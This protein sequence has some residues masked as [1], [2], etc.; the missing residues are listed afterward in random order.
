VQ[1]RS[2]LAFA[3]LFAAGCPDSNPGFDF[4][5]PGDAGADAQ[6][7]PEAMPL[8]AADTF[9]SCMAVADGFVYWTDQGGVARSDGGQAS[10]V[11]R[12][13]TAGGTAMTVADGADAPGCVVV[14]SGFAYYTN[15]AGAILRAPVAGGAP[16]PVVTGQ[17]L[18]PLR[19][20]RF[21]VGG[22]KVYWVTDVYGPVDAFSGKNAIVRAPVGGGAVEVVFTD[23]VGEPGGL[24]V[25]GSTIY[26]SDQMGMYA[27]PFGA[28]LP[29]AVGQSTLHS[30]RFAVGG[31]KLAVVEVNSIGTGD[32]AVFG[33]DGTGR[34][35]VSMSLATSLAVD[36]SG[37]YA[38]RDGR[39][40]RFALNG[41][42]TDALSDSPPR[43]IA[44]DATHVYFTDGVSILKI[45]K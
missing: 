33:L 3:A 4:S 27:R 30:N 21:A 36:D 15:G 10:K 39:L 18:L 2:I 19:T 7:L 25:L 5:V 40:V 17:H 32:V 16:Q 42:R 22:G 45:A 44:L 9:T 13:S 31:N 34:V 1:N 24:A 41:Q 23:I 11:L 14:D 29:A 20:P 26:Y 35:V 28:P 37:V 43:A 6:V 12:V 38:N 8:A